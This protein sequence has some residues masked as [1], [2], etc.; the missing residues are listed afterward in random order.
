MPK[1][2]CEVADNQIT[3]TT[4]YDP[5]K[6]LLEHQEFVHKQITEYLSMMRV[7]LQSANACSKDCKYYKGHMFKMFTGAKTWKDAKADCEAR[8]GH[9]A[10]STSAEKNTFLASLA[11]GSRAWIGGTDEGSEG[12]WRWITGEDWS[13]SNWNPGE[14]NN[15]GG[16]HYLELNYAVTNGW[17]D[18]SAT[19]TL[20]Y[21]CECEYRPRITIDPQKISHERLSE[22]L[23]GNDDGHY[24]LTED[25]IT[26]LGKLS[27][28]LIDD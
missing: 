3:A 25:E 8:G 11:G 21:L 10:T 20:G 26:K 19:K 13:Y 12:T 24:H 15:S 4:D 9:L 22:L 17:N 23:G 6:L 14:P 27:E 2:E 16:E 18:L 28:A 5:T 1:I 7:Q